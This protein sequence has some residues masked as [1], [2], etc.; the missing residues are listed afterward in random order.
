M[1]KKILEWIDPFIRVPVIGFD[2]SDQS[3]KYLAFSSHN[4][5][6]FDFFGELEVA[7]GIIVNGEIK[8]EEDLT[9]T[10]ASWLSKNKK[11]MPSFFVV[12]SLPEEKS[13][14]RL[15]QIPKMKREDVKN[16][17]KWEIEGNIP[18]P[19]GELI[20]DYEVIEPLDESADHFDVVLTAFPKII[21]ESYVRTLRA[22]TLQPYALELESQAVIRSILPQ[23]DTTLTSVVVDVGRTRTTFI[24]FNGRAIVL[25]ATIQI[26]GRIFEE[27]IAKG[28][29]VDTKS[30]VEIKK[31]TGLNRKEYE[32]KA[33]LSLVPSISV[34][35]DELQRVITYYQNQKD[36]EGFKNAHHMVHSV[37]LVGGDAN[38]LGLDTYLASILKIPVYIADPFATMRDYM[39]TRVP[40]I[41]K[42]DSLAFS[43]T[44]G[45][46]LRGT[47]KLW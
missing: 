10:L 42:R 23:L 17:I 33:F 3:I 9:R 46:A 4:G 29:G 32:G 20:Y 26:G 7:D 35:A 5:F 37:F 6:A 39:K 8:H 36:A 21:V 1:R 18:L 12:A 15:I 28:L 11:R 22:A 34:L 19:I 27:M 31:H 43:T 41:T 40:P 45:L 24:L 47:E 2:I 44:I 14:L 16:A 13:F 30:A 25:T 38:L